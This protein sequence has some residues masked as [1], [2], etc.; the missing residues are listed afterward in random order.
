MENLV[1]G[2]LKRRGRIALAGLA[3][4]FLLSA[5]DPRVVTDEATGRQLVEQG[6]LD[7]DGKRYSVFQYDPDGS[8]Q[9]NREKSYVEIDGKYVPCRSDCRQEVERHLAA[10]KPT[11]KSVFNTKPGGFKP[12]STPVPIEPPGGDGNGSG[13]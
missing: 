6:W 10:S 7:V 12:K 8:Q 11:R 2:L 5:C 9:N 1:S 3:C 4:T 13:Y